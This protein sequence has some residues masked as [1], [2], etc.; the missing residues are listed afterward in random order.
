MY[1]LNAHSVRI[2]DSS[3]LAMPPVTPPTVPPDA[4]RSSSASAVENAN[5][6]VTKRAVEA[7]TTFTITKRAKLS[8][9]KNTGGVGKQNGVVK[10]KNGMKADK[11]KRK[12]DGDHMNVE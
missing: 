5:S 6:P 4:D 10:G 1:Q 7:F 11:G 9:P 3:D 2:L 8:S 12:D